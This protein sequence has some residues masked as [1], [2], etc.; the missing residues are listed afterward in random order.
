HA[1]DYDILVKRADGKTPTILVRLARAGEILVTLD[2][3]ERKLS[4]E[5]LVIADTKG[6]IALA[7]VMG[8]L[9][10]EVTAATKN[11]L[12]ESASFDFVSV[13]RTMKQFNLPSEASVR[14][15]KGVHPETVKPA[16]ER[17]LEL[18][19]QFA[20]GTVCQGLVDCY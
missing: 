7:G 15:S 5:H 14:F 10:T 11:I 12:L 16:V 3:Q 19:R 8:G 6:P 9:E 20:A 4:P 18:M 1:F 13:R 17:A 2:K